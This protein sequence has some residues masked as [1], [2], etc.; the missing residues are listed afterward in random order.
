MGNEVNIEIKVSLNNN[1]KGRINN[2]ENIG[3][4][5]QEITQNEKEKKEQKWLKKR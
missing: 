4:N 2:I 3:L 1:K 5:G